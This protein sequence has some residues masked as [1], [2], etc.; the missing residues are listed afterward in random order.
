MLRKE[1]SKF[2]T[3]RNPKYFRLMMNYIRHMTNPVDSYNFYGLL[4]KNEWIWLTNELTFWDIKQTNSGLVGTVGKS[5]KPLYERW[6]DDT[7][8]VKYTIAK[9]NEA[10]NSANIMEAHSRR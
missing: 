2:I 7:N 10:H 3:F 4:E 8:D 6:I 9:I 5:F 1:D